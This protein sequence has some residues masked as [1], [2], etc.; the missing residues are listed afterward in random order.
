VQKPASLES[1]V[2]LEPHEA[3]SAAPRSSSARASGGGDSVLW[4][5]LGLGSLSAGVALAALPTVSWTANKIAERLADIG[6]HSGVAVVGGLTLMVLGLVRRGQHAARA[7]M[8]YDSSL[9]F[10]QIASELI[11]I[12]SS[13][14][15]SNA[16]NEKLGRQVDELAKDL[17]MTRDALASELQTLS[18]RDTNNSAL[19]QLA[20]GLDKLGLR[21]EQRLRLHHST[22]QESVDELAA[23]V[24]H[25]RRS[26]EDQLNALSAPPYEAAPYD[27][28]PLA[29]SGEVIERDS[30]PLELAVNDA[31]HETSHAQGADTA[32]PAADTNSLGLLDQFEDVAPAL[33]VLD[34]APIL[35][36]APA[37][38]FGAGQGQTHAEL[39]RAARSGRTSGNV[40]GTWDEQMMV[41]HQDLDTKTK[42]LQLESL[43]SDERLR[44]ALDAM[45]RQG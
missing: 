18:S 3:P 42:L 38:E 26:V 29:A 35:R 7:E 31:L 6:V 28:A 22:L 43:L 34:A 33:P 11:E 15:G 24:E 45:R 1:Q 17:L 44:S 41:E 27:A 5:L 21:V 19:F 9:L 37:P 30:T 32:Q 12:R 4:I 36:R 10:E 39:D 20:T 40:S 2:E 23:T 14:E 25:S 8:Q 13:L 16:R